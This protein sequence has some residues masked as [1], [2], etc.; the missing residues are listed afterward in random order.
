MNTEEGAI[1][2]PIHTALQH[3]FPSING[4]YRI[5]YGTFIN[6]QRSNYWWSCHS[7]PAC[8][9]NQR[10]SENF[11]SFPFKCM[12]KIMTFLWRYSHS[13]PCYSSWCPRA[14]AEGGSLW[15]SWC[16]WLGQVWQLEARAL[17]GSFSATGIMCVLGSD[18]G[19][20]LPGGKIPVSCLNILE[21]PS[22]FLWSLPYPGVISRHVVFDEAVLN[23][24]HSHG[25]QSDRGLTWR[26]TSHW[27]C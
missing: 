11:S 13:S 16:C 9:L 1:K 10:L 8:C 21:G 23:A 24:A 4:I 5:T 17:K 25:Q 12:I 7:W 19:T 18:V 6:G 15:S 27:A 22:S 26:V 14:E 3:Q 20:C 2:P